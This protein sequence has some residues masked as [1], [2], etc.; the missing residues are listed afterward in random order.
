[1]QTGQQTVSTPIQRAYI[2]AAS[3]LLI[4]HIL[5]LCIIVCKHNKTI[6]FVDNTVMKNIIISLT[7]D[8]YVENLH[9]ILFIFLNGNSTID[10]DEKKVLLPLAVRLQ[11]L[12][13]KRPDILTTDCKNISEQLIN[14]SFEEVEEDVEEDGEE[15]EEDG[16]EY[17]EEDV[18]EDVENCKCAICTRY[19][20]AVAGQL[21]ISENFRNSPLFPLIDKIV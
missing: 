13:L 8:E 17:V 2:V 5:K 16:E 10:T 20:L 4:Q 9:K 12:A 15:D 11:E 3:D 1:M 21:Q 6:T 7:D 19:F 18:E 14:E